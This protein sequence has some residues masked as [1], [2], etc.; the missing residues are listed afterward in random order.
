MVALRPFQACLKR[1]LAVLLYYLYYCFMI[2]FL[3]LGMNNLFL[4]KAMSGAKKVLIS[5]VIFFLLSYFIFS[6][7]MQAIIYFSFNIFLFFVSLYF[8]FALWRTKTRFSSYF[9]K[10]SIFAISGAFVANVLYLVF[11]NMSQYLGIV[12]LVAIL[13]PMLGILVEVYFFSSGLAFKSKQLEIEVLEN[14]NQIL[15]Q[16]EKNQRLLLEKEEIRNKIAQDLH[17]DVGATLSSM[18]IYG[19]LAQ[20]IWD[21]K[22]VESKQMI[23][24]IT[25]QSRDLMARMADIVWSLKPST[26][27]KNTIALRLKNYSNELLAAKEIVCHFDIDEALATTIENPFIKKNILLI[28]KEAMNNIAKYSDAQNA[29]ISFT[30]KK[31]YLLLLIHDDGKGFDTSMP[32]QGN[33]LYNMIHRCE[34]LGGTCSIQSSIQGGTTIE[35]RLPVTI[36]SPSISFS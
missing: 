2:N 31:E 27:E 29:F 19:D 11:H 28:A 21:T 33:G 9:L 16:L 36:K 20:M 1:P 26:E 8:I 6:S 34:Q 18:Q 32:S 5:A 25:E 4:A 7:H 24:K 15:E 13:F 12:Q 22:P 30:S 17:D 23:T 14:K 10:G 3:G 35:C